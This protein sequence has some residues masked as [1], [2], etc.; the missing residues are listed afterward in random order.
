MCGWRAGHW[1]WP[2]EQGRRA[3]GGVSCERRQS[4]GVGGRAAGSD[5][6]VFFKGG[7]RAAET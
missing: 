7:R 4:V 1:L 5:S 6:R 2:A 3:A